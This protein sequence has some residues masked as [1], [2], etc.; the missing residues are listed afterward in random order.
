MKNI[1]P[2]ITAPQGASGST[3][4]YYLDWLRIFAMLSIFFHHSDR[5]FDF[6]SWFV[7]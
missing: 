2:Q 3:R 7:N 5:F 6:D 1:E 4:L